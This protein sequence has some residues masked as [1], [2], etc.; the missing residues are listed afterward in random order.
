MFVY[1]NKESLFEEAHAAIITRLH[2]KGD[3]LLLKAETSQLSALKLKFITEGLQESEIMF[4][5]LAQSPLD[6]NSVKIH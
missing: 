1:Y 4:V 6:N 5:V 2:L 3:H